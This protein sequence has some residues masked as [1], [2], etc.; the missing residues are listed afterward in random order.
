[1][2]ADTTFPSGA[3]PRAFVLLKSR[4]RLELLNPDPYAWTDGDLAAGLS[5]TMRWG[6]AAAAEPRTH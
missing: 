2:T 4:R 1:M 3:A 5:R 6:G